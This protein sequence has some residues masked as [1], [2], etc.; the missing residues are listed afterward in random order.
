VSDEEV[1]LEEEDD[2]ERSLPE[3]IDTQEACMCVGS[4]VGA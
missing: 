3:S 2:D 1:L 4:G